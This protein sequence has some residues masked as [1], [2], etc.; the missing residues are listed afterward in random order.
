MGRLIIYG[1][2]LIS[3]LIDAYGWSGKQNLLIPPMTLL[4]LAFWAIHTP[5]FI[6]IG[7]AFVMGLLLDVI[8]S[9][10]L[11]H[12]AFAYVI[13]LY[14][15]VRWHRRIRV[16]P[17]WQQTLAI[18]VLVLIERLIYYWIETA[19]Y[20][21]PMNFHFLICV[22][23]VILIWPIVYWINTRIQQAFHLH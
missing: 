3:L 16:Y 14:V 18:I 5:R 6:N 11:G 7:T 15:L 12:H 1:L 17:L 20:F 22:P 2:L 9:T 8:Y 21:A 4:M 13:V 23:M 10:V 19:L